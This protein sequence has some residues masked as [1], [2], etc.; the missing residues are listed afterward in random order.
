LAPFADRAGTAVAIY[1][2]SQSIIVSVLG[3]TA[4]LLLGGDTAWPLIGFATTLAAIVILI[5]RW[6]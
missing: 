1:F 6:R 2:A 5:R 4:V 3:T